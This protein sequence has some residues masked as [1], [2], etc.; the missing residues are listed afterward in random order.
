MIKERRCP[1]SNNGGVSGQLGA[2]SGRHGIR[3]G[4]LGD[5]Y[6]RDCNEIFGNVEEA[7]QGPASSCM[8]TRR[9]KGTDPRKLWIPEV[10]GCH[11]Q[12]GVPLRKSS[13]VQE[14]HHQG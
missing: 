3:S 12:E 7:A 10:V 11:L 8:V 13:M 2:K 6:G 14:E 1:A 4:T 9:A 5:P